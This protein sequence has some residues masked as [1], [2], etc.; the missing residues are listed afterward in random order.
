[1]KRFRPATLA[2]ILVAIGV[3]RMVATFPVFSATNDE[4]THIGAGLELFQYH[5]YLLLRENPPL[6]RVV[7]AAAP[8]FGGMRYDPR[9]TFTDQIHSVFYGHGDYKANLV[10]ARVGT[11][12]F[13]LIAAIALFFTARDALGDSG[14]LAATFL[15]TMEPIVLG[16]SALATHD[17]AAV[18]GLA[19]ALFAFARW[20]RNPDLKRALIFGAAFGFSIDCKFS[21]IVFVPVTCAAIYAARLLR[22]PEL[23]RQFLRAVGSMVPAAAVTLFVVWAG[24]GFTVHT[25]GDLRP[26]MDSYPQW[27]QR[28]L[29]HVSPSFPLPAPDFFAG[30]SA[31]HKIDR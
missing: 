4:A 25:I 21:S 22:N 13:F 20:L 8:W 6:P 19:V 17:G 16:Y 23:R 15:F 24:Y 7:L 3:L 9:G 14:A 12:V 10:R 18:A 5:R 11:V 2:A 28:L 27:L 26:W 31:I 30:I 29:A 1:M